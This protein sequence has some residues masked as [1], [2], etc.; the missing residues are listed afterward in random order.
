MLKWRVPGWCG[1]ARGHHGRPDRVCRPDPA[2]LPG[3]LQGGHECSGGVF[4][5]ETTPWYTHQGAQRLVCTASACWPDGAAA[6]RSVLWDGK[7]RPGVAVVQIPIS[8]P[9]GRGK[10][11][12]RALLEGDSW[13]VVF[14]S[15]EVR[16][17]GACICTVRLRLT[18]GAVASCPTAECSPSYRPC[19]AA[20]ALRCATCH[21]ARQR[22]A[23]RCRRLQ[24]R[25]QLR[26]QLQLV[27]LHNEA[28]VI[29]ARC[30]RQDSPWAT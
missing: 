12:A 1:G 18:S 16:W 24:L 30:C 13:L 6:Q 29:C 28:T 23:A 10:L 5:G 25:Q 17:A 26:Q 7:V 20:P 15:L 21:P 11:R 14:A 4:A 22:A 2:G 3:T 9:Q 8:G 19:P 27:P